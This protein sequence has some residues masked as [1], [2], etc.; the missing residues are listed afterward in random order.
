MFTVLSG[1][2]LFAGV[3]AVS[4][5][6]GVIVQRKTNHAMQ[7]SFIRHSSYIRFMQDKHDLNR[8][9]IAQQ[10]NR[11]MGG[12]SVFG[13]S[14]STLS[15][16]GGAVF[17]LGPAVA[18][19]GTAVV[20]IGWPVLALFGLA[21]ACSLASFAS[22]VPTA[23][24]CYHWTTAI[25]GRRSG[26][27]SGWF[28]LIGT[29]LMLV[30]TNLLCAG[31]LDR[32]ASSRF[33]YQEGAWPFYSILAV[34]FVSQALVNMRGIG[35]LSRMLSAMTWVHALFVLIM[36]AALAAFAWPGFY[37]LDLLYISG[38]MNSADGA[39]HETSMLLGML[40]LQK[41]FLGSDAAAQTAEETY[42]PRINVPWGIYLSV[43]YTFIFGF[44]LFAFLVIN[45]PFGT[46]GFASYGDLPVWMDRIWARWGVTVSA[47]AA[48]LI[49][50][51]GWSSGLGTMTSASRTW[52]AMARDGV[53][54][55][56]KRAAE[57][58]ERYRT[59]LSSIVSVAAA[60]AII[61]IASGVIGWHTAELAM[62]VNLISL[63]LA[64]IHISYAIPIVIKFTAHR[65]KRPPVTQGPWQLGK[66]GLTAD[67]IS[68]LWLPAS[69]VYVIWR[70]EPT[71][72]I[73]TCTAAVLC[74][75]LIELKYRRLRGPFK[76]VDPLRFSRR[77]LD[78]MIR[79][80]RKFP[81]Q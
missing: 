17:L 36:V 79:I 78:E 9:G 69:S 57:V 58:S 32:I 20:G 45:Y 34:L 4:V 16:I 12:F 23:G 2:L 13:L 35:L 6:I 56:A 7:Q 49:A 47:V 37:P 21:T 68:L 29:V 28:N 30:T 62:L 11:H 15:V 38:P 26:M 59:P 61:S 77:T 65:H 41:M 25:G 50:L 72:Q 70:L 76:S 40:I 42:E 8:F 18:A 43:V 73:S 63:G 5:C 54:P 81:Q 19:G 31:W 51:L 24:G 75:I 53:V 55:F 66:I 44:V 10:L 14:F 74:I 46:E 71:L 52:F 48:G 67:T 60:S 39:G 22:S 27:I 33:G 1:L 64:A 3:C 80:E